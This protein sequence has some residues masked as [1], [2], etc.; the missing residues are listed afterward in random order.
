MTERLPLFERT[1]QCKLKVL[2]R[3]NPC[4]NKSDTMQKIP[5]QILN[6]IL[7]IPHCEGVIFTGSRQQ[8]TATKDSDWDFYVLL[9]DGARSFRKTWIYNGELIETFCNTLESINKY[10]LVTSK[11]SNAAIR[12]LATGE[13]VYDSEGEM[14]KVQSR[15]RQLYETGP[16]ELS[17]EDKIILGYTLRT[18]VDDLK[19]LNKL[20]VPGY[21]L[22]CIALQCVIE[23]L[24]KLERRWMAK[25]RSVERDI[26][27]IDPT[28]AE[29]YISAITATKDT[30]TEKTVE[31]I[32]LLAKRHKLPFDGEVIQYRE[33][34]K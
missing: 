13:I 4:Y 25:P 17:D 19:S 2:P 31:V 15:A 7:A 10:E 26:Q 6:Q 1:V 33:P 23:S 21:Y 3:A 18:L 28:I 14:A 11:I 12:I 27:S 30:K 24:Y 32:E 20:N 8:G 29:A 5:D 9:E 16:P 22:Q 34:P